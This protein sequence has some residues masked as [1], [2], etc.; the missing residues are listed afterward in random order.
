MNLPSFVLPYQRSPSRWKTLLFVFT[1]TIPAAGGDFASTCAGSVVSEVP[2]FSLC[3][4]AGAAGGVVAADVAVDPTV[5]SAVVFT[6]V[7]FGT[8]DL[9]RAPPDRYG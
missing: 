1:H 4:D 2:A 7:L 9:D 5:T 3:A 8:P 6:L